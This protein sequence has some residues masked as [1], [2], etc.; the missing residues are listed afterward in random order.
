[1][2]RE[3]KLI[4]Y[5]TITLGY[6]AAWQTVHELLI[7]AALDCDRIL[8]TPP[9][10]VLHTSLNDYHVSYELNASTSKPELLPRIYSD[11]HKNIQERF[12]AAGVEIMS[13]AYTALRDGNTI[14]LPPDFRPDDYRPPAFRA[15][16]SSEGQR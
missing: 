3:N 11:L 16:V 5:T 1:M 9:P 6:D 10:F 13:P 2:A 8:R 14:T 15:R 4:V 12:N 7:A